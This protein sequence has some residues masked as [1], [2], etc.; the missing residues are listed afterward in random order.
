MYDIFNRSSR[1]NKGEDIS[2][3][4]ADQMYGYCPDENGK[5]RLHWVIKVNAFNNVN[6]PL[7]TRISVVCKDSYVMIKAVLDGVKNLFGRV[8]GWSG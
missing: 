1:Y 5:Q 4:Y 8:V 3:L 7:N 6:L 2:S